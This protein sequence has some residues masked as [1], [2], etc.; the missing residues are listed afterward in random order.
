[1]Y[2]N[3]N[4]LM[5]LLIIT[6]VA[7]TMQKIVKF[8]TF[9]KNMFWLCFQYRVR[10]WGGQRSTFADRRKSVVIS[11]GGSAKKLRPT[12]PNPVLVRRGE[13]G[14]SDST[15]VDPVRIWRAV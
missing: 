15:F 12:V 1:M 10:Y 2:R 14:V 8:K 4:V 6:V 11:K 7:L 5:V 3:K 9:V 13:R